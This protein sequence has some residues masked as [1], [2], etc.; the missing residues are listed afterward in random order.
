[1][2]FDLRQQVTRLRDVEGVEPEIV[3]GA[4]RCGY[5]F[6]LRSCGFDG[7]DDALYAVPASRDKENI[8]A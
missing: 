5:R 1:M 8:Y 3:I 6:F 7:L 4:Q 2:S